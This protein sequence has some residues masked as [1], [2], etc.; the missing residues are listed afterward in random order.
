MYTTNNISPY[1]LKW[2]DQNKRD[3]PWRKYNDLYH[4][5]LSEVMLQQTKVETVIPYYI[6]W[7]NKYPTIESVALSNLDDLLKLWEGLGYYSRCV[8]F[9]KACIILYSQ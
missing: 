7:L 3:L 1:L 5:Y 2:Y 6:R 4:V 8:N 9:Y